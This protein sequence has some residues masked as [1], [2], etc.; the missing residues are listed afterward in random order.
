M[1][2]ISDSFLQG[3]QSGQAIRANYDARK[4]RRSLQGDTQKFFEKLKEIDIP[5]D[6]GNEPAQALPMATNDAP[7]ATQG[8]AVAMTTPSSALPLPGASPDVAP[9]A[10]RTSIARKDLEDLDTI[11][12]RMASTAGDPKVYDAMRGIASQQMQGRVLREFAGA[13]QAIAAGDNKALEKALGRVNFLLP[14]EIDLNLKHGADGQLTYKNPMTNKVEPFTADTLETYR[15]MAMNPATFGDY[16]WN[17]KQKEG[18]AAVSAKNA[19]TN[20]TNAATQ[21][22]QAAETARHNQ[23]SEALQRGAQPSENLQR[24]A[25]AVQ[26]LANARYLDFNR[27]KG[28][29]GA[30]GMKPDDARQFASAVRSVVNDTL[31]PMTN[32]TDPATG[33]PTK[34]P[35][36]PIPGYEHATPEDMNRVSSIAEQIG[37]SNPETGLSSAAMY[38][39]AIDRAMHGGG[40]IK[41]DPNTGLIGIPQKNG[42]VITFKAPPQ[43]IQQLATAAQRPADPRVPPMLA[44]PQPGQA[45][46]PPTSALPFR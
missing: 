12:A 30:D 7:A 18:E 35:G 27:G 22:G 28:A 10:K 17:R 14:D 5:G 46:A 20:A 3:I 29:G 9:P 6:W 25:N 40:T 21:A 26:A 41:V 42:Q 23:A 32:G 16:I 19:E 31:F 33:Q 1:S 39:T 13:Q 11:A 4:E 36:T 38:A 34:V 37:V 24:N 44:R 2:N 8:A 45:P 15:Q 43:L